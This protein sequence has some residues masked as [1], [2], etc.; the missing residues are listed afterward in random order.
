MDALLCVR[1]S[2]SIFGFEIYWYGVIIAFAIIVAFILASFVMKKIGFRDEI[3][4]EVLLI[5]IP[6]G[7]VGARVFYLI[8]DPD[9]SLLNFFNIRDGGLAIYGAV[10]AGALGVWIYTRFIRKSSFFAISDI[11]VLVL[12]LAQSIGRWGNYFNQELFGLSTGKFSFFPFTVKIAYKCTVHAG[13]CNHLAL[14]FYESVLN[15]VGFLI[16]AKVFS[17]QKKY[18]TTTGVYLIIYGTIRA[19]LEPLRVNQYQLGHVLPVSLLV[20]VLAVGLGI[21]LLY[22]AKLDKLPQKDIALRET[23]E[24]K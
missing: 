3:V 11:V 23:K 16:L 22:L 6:L 10:L 21:L 5:I 20:S 17:K 8:F 14:F 12:I 7:I 2:F 15:L 9:E 1:E 4:Y 13:E 19:I 18:G 24:K